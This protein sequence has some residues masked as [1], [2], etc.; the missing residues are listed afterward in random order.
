MRA[1]AGVRLGVLELEDL[2]EA[3]GLELEVVGVSWGSWKG[4]GR[5]VDCILL[6]F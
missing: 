5:C 2:K 6:S 3:K 1:C 4:Q